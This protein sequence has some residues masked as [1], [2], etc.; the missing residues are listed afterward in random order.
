MKAIPR[1]IRDTTLKTRTT[2]RLAV[3]AR[4]IEQANKRR[5]GSLNF[6]G[7]EVFGETEGLFGEGGTQV[8]G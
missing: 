6:I 4:R 8:F 5:R 7:T 1:K 3:V 2:T